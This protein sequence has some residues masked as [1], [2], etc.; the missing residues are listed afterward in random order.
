MSTTLEEIGGNPSGRVLRSF[1]SRFVD[2]SG[3]ITPGGLPPGL[4]KGVD[5]GQAGFYVPSP[6]PFVPLANTLLLAN[7]NYAVRFVAPRTTTI[8]SISF[9]V[10]T[11]ASADDPCD[12]AI[13]NAAGT[14]VLSSSGST[15]AKL[16]TTGVKNVALQSPVPVVAG[17]VYYGIF[18]C[19]PVGGTAASIWQFNLQNFTM[20]SIFGSA[21]GVVESY[22]QAPAFPITIPFPAMAPSANGPILALLE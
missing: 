6:A 1:L 2:N 10:G 16:N 8:R 15:A 19:G 3:Q 17:T 14:A 7:R 5:T 13:A 20:V 22:S 21:W 11:A 4:G 18:A 9:S 12:L